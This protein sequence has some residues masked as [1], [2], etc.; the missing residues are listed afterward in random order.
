MSGEWIEELLAGWW[1]AMGWNE[2]APPHRPTPVVIVKQPTPPR[3][4]GPE[5]PR[6]SIAA[7]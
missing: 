4:K 5:I 6:E 7:L 3:G 2:F 1:D